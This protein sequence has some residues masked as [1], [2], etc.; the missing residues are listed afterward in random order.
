MASNP[1]FASTATASWH[2]S[3]GIRGLLP[4][5]QTIARGPW[6]PSDPEPDVISSSR[7]H[8]DQ[9]QLGAPGAGGRRALE[10]GA[11]R[12]GRAQVGAQGNAQS[13]SA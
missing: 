3:H 8:Q 9:T 10:P 7:S 4:G 5:Y 6:Q 1:F 2:C 12:G 13:R 11:R